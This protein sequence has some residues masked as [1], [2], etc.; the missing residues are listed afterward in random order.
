MISIA[1]TGKRGGNARP[2]GREFKQLAE[3][4]G[5]GDTGALA[6]KQQIA[7]QQYAEARNE[8]SRLRYELQRAEDDLQGKQA[9]VKV[10]ESAPNS[11]WDLATSNDPTVD[12]AVGSNRGN[13]RPI[14]HDAREAQGTGAREGLGGIQADEEDPSREGGEAGERARREVAEKRKR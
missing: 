4:L 9:W 2:A 13:R 11:D 7:M 10:L 6:L 1:S 12:A 14:G 8:L 5:T 3:Q